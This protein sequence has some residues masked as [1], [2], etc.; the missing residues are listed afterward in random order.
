MIYMVVTTTI[1]HFIIVILKWLILMVLNSMRNIGFCYLDVYF[2]NLL[3]SFLI[4]FRNP[5]AYLGIVG[6]AKR[7]TYS[8]G[9]SYFYW[10]C[11]FL[12]IKCFIMLLIAYD[13]GVDGLYLMMLTK[14]LLKC[15][16][17]GVCESTHLRCKTS[18]C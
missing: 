4:G 7:W 10:L 8:K 11:P 2:S 18:L 6:A 13:L 16:I 1:S 15:P 12:L 17:I 5:A 9:S 3:L 14:C